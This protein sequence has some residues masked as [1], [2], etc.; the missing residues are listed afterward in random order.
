[1]VPAVGMKTSAPSP[2][3]E[4]FFKKNQGWRS[5]ENWQHTVFFL[6]LIK[7]FLNGINVLVRTFLPPRSLGNIFSGV[8]LTADW[9]L[10]Q[11]LFMVRLRDILNNSAT[12]VDLAP[13]QMR[14]PQEWQP[15]DKSGWILREWLLLGN[16]YFVSD[17][18]ED[19][20]HFLLSSFH[21]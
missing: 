12:C 1:M 19:D 9:H 20:T 13:E 14:K 5:K 16:G 7:E 2:P 21:L 10:P 17:D 8:M 3:R 6:K 18:A 4:W 15:G 11:K